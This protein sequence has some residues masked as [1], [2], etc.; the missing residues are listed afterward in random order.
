MHGAPFYVLL[1]KHV[2]ADQ[3]ALMGQVGTQSRTCVKGSPALASTTGYK[4]E[5]QNLAETSALCSRFLNLP[6]LSGR[7]HI[8][9]M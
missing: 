2:Q 8:Y 4:V 1:V 5:E 6:K 9:C 7:P 3:R